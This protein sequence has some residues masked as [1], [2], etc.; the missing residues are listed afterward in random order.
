MEKKLIIMPK[1]NNCSGN[2]KKQWFVY[3]SVRN[4]KTG[5]MQR[6]RSYDG[7]TGLSE[8]EKL[9]HGRKLIEEY[10]IK[11]RSGWTPFK[12]NLIIYEDH[13]D[14]KT[15]AEIY[16]S[17][18]ASNN[19]LRVIVSRFMADI[20]PAHSLS[21]IQTYCSKLRI[22]TLW[23]EKYGYTDND[24]SSYSNPLLQEF[25]RYLINDKKLSGIS[26]KKYR[27]LLTY[28]F[29]FCITRK[30]VKTNPVFNIPRC[31]RITDK[32][33]RP[34]LKEDI[35]LFK[36]ELSKDPEL[37]LA[38]QLE[39][40]CALRP[41][42]EIREMRIKDIDLI[43]GRIRVDRN[44]AKNRQERLI[45]VPRQLVLQLREDY[46][47]QEYDREFYVFGRHG[48]PGPDCMAKNKLGRKFNA[49]R[50]KLNMPLEYKLY[51]WKHTGAILADEA[52]IPLKDISYHLGHSSLSATDF[53]FRN[54]KVQTSVA[55][56][57]HFPTL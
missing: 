40:Y 41:G 4:P 6:F 46:R 42:H 1:L 45:T 23:T 34:I 30:Y 18:R 56:R 28:F 35:D 16:R 54:K 27:E 24:I 8:L 55:I 50:K 52:N 49:V 48:K 47:L 38:I 36:R 7:F 31:T 33:P 10:S 3:F 51:S 20:T 32:A 17:K 57:D 11:L 29:N 53:Y 44:R 37:W 43:E 5:K 15:Q 26:I 39:Y 25:F 22:F 9:E 21:T 19:S 12:D 14:Y 2:L 13:V